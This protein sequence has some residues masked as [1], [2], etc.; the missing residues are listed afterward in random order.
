MDDEGELLSGR[1]RAAGFE[2]VWVQ[3]GVEVRRPL[4]EVA[5]EEVAPVREFPRRGRS[6]GWRRRRGRRARSRPLW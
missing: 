5:F 3:G 6:A 4:A 1:D 2:V